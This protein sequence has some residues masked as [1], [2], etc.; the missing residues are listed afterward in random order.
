MLD[1]NEVMRRLDEFI[2]RELNDEELAEVQAHLDR[3]G[4]CAERFRFEENVL[5]L[6]GRCGRQLSAPPELVRRVRRMCRDQT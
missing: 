4:H 3:C 5:R 6:V 2:D 1:C